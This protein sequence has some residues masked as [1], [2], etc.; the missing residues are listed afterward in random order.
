LKTLPE[1][2]NL[3]FYLPAFFFGELETVF[4]ILAANRVVLQTVKLTVFEVFQHG[5]VE[6]VVLSRKTC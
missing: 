3:N 6:K 1:G 5:R 2:K 4:F